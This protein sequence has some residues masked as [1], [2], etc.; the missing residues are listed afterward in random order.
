MGSWR[1]GSSAGTSYS[2]IPADAIG[3]ERL[4]RFCGEPVSTS[5]E[6][7]ICFAILGGCKR[8]EKNVRSSLAILDRRSNPCARL[9]GGGRCGGAQSGR[10]RLPIARPDQVES[11]ERGGLAECRRG[12]RSVEAG[13]L[14]RAQQ[15]AER[16]PFQ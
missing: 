10:R 7:A 15:M 2:P 1:D 6:N 3:R 11:A 14:C 5:P 8:E 16:Q 13:A 12:R 9:D 4:T